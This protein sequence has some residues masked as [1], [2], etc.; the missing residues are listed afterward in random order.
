MY[1]TTFAQSI[2]VVLLLETGE[3]TDVESE[4]VLQ[5][6]LHAGR[7]ARRADAEIQA[8]SATVET[9]HDTLTPE[10]DKRH[11][12]PSEIRR[13]T[14]RQVDLNAGVTCEHCGSEIGFKH[15]TSSPVGSMHQGCAHEH[16]DRHPLLW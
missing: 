8:V 1:T 9:G 2:A 3:S 15:G 5:A 13:W 14:E 16:E 11:P 10:M 12:S 6:P 4:N 7:A